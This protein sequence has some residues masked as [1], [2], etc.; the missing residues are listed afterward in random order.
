MIIY[1]RVSRRILSAFAIT[2]AIVLVAPLFAVGAT[3]QPDDEPAILRIGFLEIVDSM[4]PFV[5]LTESAKV[6]YGLVYDCLQAVDGDLEPVPNLAVAWE[7]DEEYEP[8]GSAWVMD[9]AQDVQ[10]HDGSPFTV[11]D[12]IFTIN[13][14][15]MNYSVLWPMRPYAYFL[16]YAEKVDEDTIRIHFFDRETGTP[17][18]A[19][20]ADM[21]CM[22]ILPEHM[23]GDMSATEIAFSWTGVFEDSDPPLI[24][25]GMF[26]ATDDMYQEYLD[27]EKLTL[28][29]NPNYHK[30]GDDGSPFVSFDMLELRVYESNTEM[31]R[32][33]ENGTLD[34]ACFAPHGFTDIRA[35]IDANDT[36]NICYYSGQTCSQ[37]TKLLDI[38]MRNGIGGNPT[39]LDPIVRQAIVMALNKTSM[40][41]DPD[42]YDGLAEEGSTIIPPVNSKWHCELTANEL[43]DY[44]VQAAN[45]LLES[46]GYRYTP[47][48]QD[49]RVATADSW[50]VQQELV[51]EGFPLEFELTCFKTAPEDVFIARLISDAGEDIGVGLNLNVITQYYPMWGVHIY[52]PVWEYYEMTLW[53]W[54]SHIDPAYHLFRH[55]SENAGGWNDNYYS[56][57]AYDDNFTKSIAALDE[58]ERRGYVHACQRIQYQDTAYV[59]L[60]YMHDAFAWRTDAFSGWVNCSQEPG[61]SITNT[62][63]AN[64]LISA[65]EP[66]TDDG[67][68]DE[69][70]VLTLAVPAIAAV[71]VIAY[72]S[73]KRKAT[74]A[75]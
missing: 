48:S 66:V 20:Y 8:L 75:S 2:V 53:S 46:N 37:K 45:D 44:D 33:L 58:D 29:R 12:V 72:L 23:L 56:N 10:W 65:L 51:P 3:S 68:L 6:F 73:L 25:T 11:D 35:S 69:N 27:G 52:C 13:L 62:W 42:V 30:N 21:M 36:G 59:T 5:G 60:A 17:M 15:A 55:Y 74:G 50:A 18:P 63:G 43:L 24:G 70:I 7:V 26:M 9:I 14:N 19:A 57:A 34:L 22:P 32:E 40:I 47:S 38:D 1:G 71:A 28:V 41:S 54:T 16:N 31:I 64:P 4:N 39:R 49:V 67:S 61:A